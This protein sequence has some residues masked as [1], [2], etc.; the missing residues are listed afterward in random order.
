M[1]GVVLV[2]LLVFGLLLQ[3]AWLATDGLRDRDTSTGAAR[4][5]EEYTT[6]VWEDNGLNADS[7]RRRQRFSR[8]P[9]LD[10]LLARFHMADS[11]SRDL[12]KAGVAMRAGEFLFLQL[13]TTSVAGF[14]AFL[15]L[16]VQFGAILPVVVAGLLGFFAPL[17]WLRMQR[18]KRLAQ[19]EQDLPD[20]LDLIAG[21]LRAGYGIVHGFEL[22]AHENDGPCGQ[23]LGQ[24]LQ[25][26]QLGAEL[27][28]ALAR[29]TERVTSEDARLLATA[30]AV[31]RRTG[32]N[33]V[34]VLAQMAHVLRERQRLR[35]EVAVITTA[36]RISGYVVSLL[37]VLVMVGMYFLSR[38]YLQMLFD[39][40]IGRMALVGSGVMVVIGLLIN[41]RIAS[42]EM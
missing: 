28:S 34:D 38:Y 37:P 19:F 23:E 30:V 11:L 21:S 18:N 8:L 12:M 6:I 29:I 33:L 27:D 4:R 3:A 5:V 14:A 32:G 22:V 25:E 40:P 13:V 31:Q 39:E 9:W 17:A 10:A 15:L 16:S 24:V 20:A 1:T 36:P 42:V 41:R 7:I 2:T 35:R 26:V